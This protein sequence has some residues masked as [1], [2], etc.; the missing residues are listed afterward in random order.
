MF[1]VIWKS[2]LKSKA[3]RITFSE[4]TQKLTTDIKDQYN[5]LKSIFENILKKMDGNID[6]MISIDICKEE[7][8]FYNISE[9]LIHCVMS[10]C[11]NDEFFENIE[12]KRELFDIS[13]KIFKLFMLFDL[14]KSRNPRIFSYYCEMRLKDEEPFREIVTDIEDDGIS[15]L[16]MITMPMGRLFLS[17]FSSLNFDL[18]KPLFLGKTSKIYLNIENQRR[19]CV[20]IYLCEINQWKYS[21]IFLIALFNR[22]VNSGSFDLKD[23]ALKNFRSY[24]EML[25]QQR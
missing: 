22:V 13:N 24:L 5:E 12:R 16:N 9:V 4:R 7:L 21:F 2:I 20:F 8:S 3:E 25:K 15:M 1:M 10:E 23:N 14:M 18:S 17:M 11:F 6:F 19:L